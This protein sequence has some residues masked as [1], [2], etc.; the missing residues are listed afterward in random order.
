MSLYHT[1]KQHESEYE[2]FIILIFNIYNEISQFTTDV[3]KSQIFFF[4]G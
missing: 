1:N 3:K 2:T 4:D